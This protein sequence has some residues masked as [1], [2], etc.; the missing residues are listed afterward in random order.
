MITC[1]SCGFEN[2]LMNEKC[3]K[4]G[5]FLGFPNVNDCSQKQELEALEKRYQEKVELAAAKGKED[6]RIEFEEEVKKSVA[7]INVDL[8]YLHYFIVGKHSLYSTY[9]LQTGAETRDY[10]RSEFDKE[11][12]GIEGTLFGSYGENLRYAAL[13]LDGSGLKSY[14]DFTIIL[15]DEAVKLRATLL[16]ENSY[17]FIRRHKILA[18]GKIPRGYKAVW[19]D[20]HKLAVAKLIKSILTKGSNYAKIVL[21]STGDRKKDDFIEVYIYGKLS[22][23]SI[24]SVK[25]NSENVSEKHIIARIKDKLKKDN[26][27]WI[28]EGQ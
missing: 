10:T 2:S 8:D 13:S 23:E 9:Q 16:E 1:P 20:R 26:K 4:C 11:R 6:K 12:L 3:S 15:A 7:V 5:M 24:L 27:N 25:G 21:N 17:R 22:K 28:E 14:G 19:K 18:G